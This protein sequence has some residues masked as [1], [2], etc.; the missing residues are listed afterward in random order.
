MHVLREACRQQLI[1]E[2]D[3]LDNVDGRREHMAGAAEVARWCVEALL[4][5]R[6][7]ALNAPALAQ[8]DRK[9]IVLKLADDELRL[10][11]REC[12]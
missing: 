2:D 5:A 10:A 8:E 7:V 3:E 1:V 9:R 12:H 4:R 11:L 6:R